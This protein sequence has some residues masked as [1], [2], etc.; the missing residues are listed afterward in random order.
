MIRLFAYLMQWFDRR[1]DKYDSLTV[2]FNFTDRDEAMRF[3]YALRQEFNDIHRVSGPMD[4][5]DIRTLKIMGIKLKIESPIH[6][7]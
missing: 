1:G 7:N 3:D 5:A 6:P 4:N 2:I